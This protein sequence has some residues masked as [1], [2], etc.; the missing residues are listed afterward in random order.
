MLTAA[1]ILALVTSILVTLEVYYGVGRHAVYLPP[2]NLIKAVE[3]IWLTAP[4]STMSACFGK[5]SIALLL[6]RI[7]SRNAVYKTF[8]WCMIVTLF[9]V[10]L[11]LTI[12]T[13]SQCTPVTFLWD[14]LN[15]HVNYSGSCWDPH[16]QQN[17]GYFQGGTS[18][19]LPC[20][21]T[22]IPCIAFS[23][24]SDLVLAL[25][26]IL[27]VWNLQMKLKL[28]AGLAAVMGLGVIATVASVFKTVELKNLSTPDFTYDATDLVYWYITENWLI[29]IAACF[30]TLGPLYMVTTGRATMDSFQRNS[31]PRVG[32]SGWSRWKPR[33]L[34]SRGSSAKYNSKGSYGSSKASYSNGSGMRTFN[35]SYVHD[36]RE[37][38]HSMEPIVRPVVLANPRGGRSV[39]VQTDISVV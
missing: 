20:N 25:F 3:V 8:L 1:Q 22:L 11:L 2:P 10:N 7:D 31:H 4:F 24:F 34:F 12:I 6:M 27:I 5:I 21:M 17:Y 16:V 36:T 18:H 26:P 35:N 30:P 23:S 19:R 39:G 32:L 9:I 33:L 14:R 29:I 13:F 15:P 28:K 37:T 38:G